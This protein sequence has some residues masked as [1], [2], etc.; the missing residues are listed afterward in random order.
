MKL[1]E[2]LENKNIVDK[3]SVLLT[4]GK[5][6]VG[7]ELLGILE[8]ALTEKVIY[9]ADFNDLK[10]VVDRGYE[11]A[12]E[13]ICS[14]I[15]SM[16]RNAFDRESYSSY[17]A[18]ISFMF[19]RLSEAKKHVREYK[20]LANVLKS[21]A[22][23]TNEIQDAIAKA[24]EIHTLAEEFYNLLK[25]VKK[26]VVKGRKP[27]PVDPNAFQRKLGSHEAQKIVIDAIKKNIDPKLDDFEKQLRDLFEGTADRLKAEIKEHNGV[28][29]GK[30][31]EIFGTFKYRVLSGMWMFKIDHSYKDKT[32]TLSN[33][34]L[35]RPE[36]PAKE[37][38][39]Y[40]T[41]IEE[42][43]IRKNV[44]KLSMIVDNKGNLKKIT[45]LPSKAV[46][47]VPT[48]ST[49]EAGLK[50][51]FEDGSS[52]EVVN[53]IITKQSAGNRWQRG[54][55]FEQY[56]TTFH[57]VVMSDGSRMKTPSEEKMVKEFK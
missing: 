5:K 4:P 22:A 17:T 51:E 43:F 57:N 23:N 50:F 48:S 56:P 12:A 37:A 40:R 32:V 46:H 55:M 45:E 16:L 15:M 20:T 8:K 11:K 36:W 47:V 54:T 25:E 26:Y 18:G 9:N 52:F 1:N 41:A 42:R 14:S 13:P 27:K 6:E 49:I 31:D 44:H 34:E 35:D 24:I 10:S 21:L 7:I 29:S 33:F 53:K 3:F 38:K 19:F 30:K 39:S 2:V 28:I